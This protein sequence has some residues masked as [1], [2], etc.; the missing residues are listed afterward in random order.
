MPRYAAFLR[1]INV[2]GHRA[3]KDQLC[4]SFESVGL[5]DVATFRASG[6]VVFTAGGD[7]VAKLTARIEAALEETLG[8]AAPT[9]LRSDREMRTMAAHQPFPAKLLN[10][11]KGK[12]QVQMLPKRPTAKAQKEVLALAT[13]DDPLAFGHRELYWLPSGGQLESELDWKA[14]DKALGVGTRRTKGTVDLIAARW[15]AG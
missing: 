10:A 9:F 5:T 6:N 13:D 4:S 15:F 12:L 14:I 11:S 2:G 7:S 8:Y 1:G 3:S